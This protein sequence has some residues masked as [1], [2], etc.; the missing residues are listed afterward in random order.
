[1][2][3]VQFDDLAGA[4]AQVLPKTE[5]PDGAL[6]LLRLRR[7]DDVFAG[8]DLRGHEPA[9]WVL[10]L[11]AALALGF[12]SLR[13]ETWRSRGLDVD[14]GFALLLGQRQADGRWPAG[15]S[16]FAADR[17]PLSAWLGGRSFDVRGGEGSLVTAGTLPSAAAAG[18]AWTSTLASDDP[19]LELCVSFGVRRPL[20]G[21]F[22]AASRRADRFQV[23]LV[24]RLPGLPPL[25]VIARDPPRATDEVLPLSQR[26]LQLGGKVARL[27]RP[28]PGVLAP[29]SWDEPGPC[30]CGIPPDR[31]AMKRFSLAPP[32][33]AAAS[34]AFGADSFRQLTASLVDLSAV[35]ASD[36]PEIRAGDR[37]LV[38]RS[39][40]SVEAL[41]PDDLVLDEAGR[42]GPRGARAAPGSAAI[43]AALPWPPLGRPRAF[44][45]TFSGLWR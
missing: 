6:A 35:R 22:L 24:A 16:A 2:L 32:Q 3:Y 40:D 39:P 38:A 45:R 19:Y 26:L 13:T 21:L 44:R 25:H 11:A 43:L 10:R 18:S 15:V 23:E 27:D 5:A 37:V 34:D 30:D 41:A 17:G 12:R 8:L 33:G 42:A 14:R 9:I 7:L 1:M 36:T 4:A 29:P 20:G 28:A 31:C